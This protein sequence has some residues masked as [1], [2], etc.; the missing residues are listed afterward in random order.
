[1]ATPQQTIRFYEFGPFLINSVERILLRDGEVVPLT[2]KQFDLLLVLVERCGHVVEKER[3]MEEV[4]P[5]TAVEE[6]NLTVN[7]STLRKALEEGADGARYIQ[8]LP[9]RG[10]RFVGQV[11]EIADDDSGLIVREQTQSRVVKEQEGEDRR[12]DMASRRRGEKQEN[13]A[14][15][16]H[17]VTVSPLMVLATCGLFI[18]T[19]AI[20]F[21]WIW[22]KP[23]PPVSDG[24]MKSIAVLP[25]KPLVGGSRDE[26]LELGMTD[27]LINKLSSIRQLIVRPISDVRKYSGLEQDPLAAGRELR[28]DYVL[29]ANIHTVGEK[30]KVT[31]RLLSVK[32]GSAVSADKCDE[33]CG[34]VFELQDAIAG[35]I[36]G[37][38]ALK[39]TD[40]EKKQLAKRYTN[41]PEAHQLYSLGMSERD[42]KKKMEYFE[43][44]IKIDPNYALAYSGLCNVYYILLSRGIWS[45]KEARQ[46]YEWAALMAVELDD[47]LSEAHAQLGYVKEYNWDW[48]GAEK[49]FK[50]ALE[51]NPNSYGAHQ[52]YNWFLV[53][54]GR[55]DEALVIAE[56]AEKLAEKLNVNSRPLVAY[57]Y[58]HKREYDAAIELYLS[59]PPGQRFLLAYAYLAKGMHAEAIAQMQKALANENAAVS[60]AGHPML[61][62]TNALAGKRDEAMRILDEQRELAKRRYISPYNFAIIY[63][64]LGDKDRAFEYLNKAY[65]EHP[66]TMVHLKSRPMFDSLRSDPRYTELL[67]KMNLA[68]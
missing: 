33:Q 19:G 49:E 58:L 48:A 59:N 60:W 29:E 66:Q 43:R 11:I 14:A 55:F 36:A 28:V 15:T 57:V 40:E 16:R 53:D 26:A 27:T 61:A 13:A 47:T 4:W 9:R 46:K 1:M 64:G 52:A 54:V 68:Q 32:D 67:R 24:A 35:Q 34:N 42:N 20:F 44:A 51:L 22:N 38:L 45:P 6:G 50:R 39:L 62:Y 30:T 12:G 37:E 25:F 21:F 10:Y 23:K 18:V 5:G 7:I 56:R 65:E 2:P 3:L 63:L 31:W 41:S 8:T 17:R